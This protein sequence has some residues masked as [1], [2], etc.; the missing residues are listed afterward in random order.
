MAFSVANDRETPDATLVVEYAVN[1]IGRDANLKVV[2]AEVV[3]DTEDPIPVDAFEDADADGAFEVLTVSEWK[4]RTDLIGK[5]VFTEA[6]VSLG[7]I[8]AFADET[9]LEDSTVVPAKVTLSAG[10][11]TA[12]PLNL[13]LRTHMTGIEVP[14]YRMARGGRRWEARFGTGFADGASLVQQLMGAAYYNAVAVVLIQMGVTFT[15]QELVAAITATGSNIDSF[16]AEQGEVVE[17]QRRAGQLPWLA[18]LGDA[19][20]AQG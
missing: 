5:E 6:K 10:V 2:F 9:V 8:T 3:F 11:A 20:I 16:I 19:P 4:G 17:E 15:P 7:T 14:A 12:D 18:M 13:T 1:R